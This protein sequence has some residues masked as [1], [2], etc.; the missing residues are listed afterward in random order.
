MMSVLRF[1]PDCTVKNILFEDY[2]SSAPRRYPPLIKR[3]A[4][5]ARDAGTA[6]SFV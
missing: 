5:V 6:V 4:R 1:M 3:V 2:D